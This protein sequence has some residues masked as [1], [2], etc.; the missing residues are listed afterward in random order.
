[1]APSAAENSMGNHDWLGWLASALLL[2]T[3]GRQIW[4]Q[5][6]ERSTQGVSGWMFIGQISASVCFAVYSWLIGSWVF[7]ATN[8]ALIVTALIGQWIYRRNVKLEEKNGK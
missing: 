5:W 3:L 6:R 4:V 7:V 2:A 1:M 8:L